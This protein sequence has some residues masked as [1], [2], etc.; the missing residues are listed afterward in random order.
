MIEIE[1]KFL[2]KPKHQWAPFVTKSQRIA[3]G[4]V[5]GGGATNTVRVRILDAEAFLTIK[6]PSTGISRLEFEYPI[7][8]EDAATML[9]ELCGGQTIDKTR[10]HVHIGD[11]LW[12]I[13][14]FHGSH[15]GLLLAEVELDDEK[16]DIEI[17]TWIAR[18]V[19]DDPRYFNANLIGA[20]TPPKD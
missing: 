8:V 17:P 3:Q 18:E 4:Y 7:P 11:L 20:P 9:A 13:D 16:T 1:R 6:G 5:T 2:V 15:E 10:H 14:E 12:T 19:S